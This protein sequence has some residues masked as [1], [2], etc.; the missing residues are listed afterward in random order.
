MQLLDS[1]QNP[2]FMDKDTQIKLVSSDPSILDVP[3]NVVIKQGDYYSFFNVTA[4]QAGNAEL[5]V[6]AND[7]PLS[8]IAVVVTNVLPTIGITSNDYVNPNTAFDAA[9]TA[10]YNNAP[11]SGLK[12][13]WTAKGATIQSMDSVTDK[14]GKAKITLLSQDPTKIDIK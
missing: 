13:D 3:E 2:V 8:K 4:K 11:L 7:I 6:L 9:L 10:Q 5:S 14:D 12:V 1:Q